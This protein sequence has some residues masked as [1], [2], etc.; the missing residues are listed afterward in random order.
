MTKLFKVASAGVAAVAILAGPA[1]AAVSV[2]QNQPTSVAAAAK[3][4]IINLNVS[5]M[6]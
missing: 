1:M 4:S 2:D 3:E 6:R 5:G